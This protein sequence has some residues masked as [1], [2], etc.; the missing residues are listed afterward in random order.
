[1]PTDQKTRKGPPKPSKEAIKDALRPYRITAA[2]L[3]R[4]TSEIRSPRLP[5]P[6]SEIESE[7]RLSGYIL[8]DF[9][10]PDWID[11]YLTYKGLIR[12][13]TYFGSDDNFYIRVI[14]LAEM[15]LNLQDVP[16]FRSCL[17]IIARGDIEAGFAELEAAKFLSWF[18]VRF[19]FNTPRAKRKAD[20]DLHVIFRNGNFGYGET[21][22]KRETGALTGTTIFNSLHHARKQLPNDKPA[23]IFLK[24]PETWLSQESH[25]TIDPQIRKFLRGTQT[26]VAVDI[27]ATDFRS[28]AG[29]AEPIIAGVEVLNLDHK[30]DRTLDWSLIGPVLP[31]TKSIVPPTWWRSIPAIIDPKVDPRTFRP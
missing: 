31:A 26:V 15:L 5:A 30:F 1:M 16:G 25:K 29:I 18:G 17:S 24:L 11:H 10:G 14:T 4:M 20:F 28:K 23:V 2:T 13:S 3:R 12:G 21:E 27:F 6:I 8:L 9:F 7:F 22:S 19:S